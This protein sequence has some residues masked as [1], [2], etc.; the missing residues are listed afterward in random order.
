MSRPI[1]AL[2]AVLLALLPIRVSETA[3][4]VVAAIERGAHWIAE[5]RD[6]NGLRVE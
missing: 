4:G 2:A 5:T 6:E 1:L 3:S